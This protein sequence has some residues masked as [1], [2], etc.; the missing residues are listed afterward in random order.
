MLDGGAG[1]DTLYSEA[2]KD[3]F[4]FTNAERHAKSPG[5]TIKDMDIKDDRIGL[6]AQDGEAFSDGLSW[7]QG[8][9]VGTLLKADSYFEGGTGNDEEDASR[10]LSGFSRFGPV[11]RYH[12]R[13]L[14]QP[15]VG[16]WRG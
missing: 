9:V 2:G 7:V 12:R 1:A 8:G 16:C 3:R 15:Y 5:A 4:D 14:V 13:P 6:A 11:K 10:N